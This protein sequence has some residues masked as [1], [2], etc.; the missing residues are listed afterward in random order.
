MMVIS[1]MSKAWL[2]IQKGK[3]NNTAHTAN[4]HHL[5]FAKAAKLFAALLICCPAKTSLGVAT[6][7]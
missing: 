5:G 7:E 4:S 1:L 3:H 6:S 2:G